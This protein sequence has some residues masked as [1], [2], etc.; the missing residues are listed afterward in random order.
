MGPLVVIIVAIVIIFL[1]QI[2]KLKRKDGNEI[3]EA[4]EKLVARELNKY[5]TENSRLLNDVVLLDD[6]GES[7]QIDHIFINENGVWIIE[8]KNWSGMIYGSDEQKEWTQVLA[9]GKEKNRVYSPVKQ[10]LTHVYKIQKILKKN[11]PLI[12]LV[13]FISADINNVRSSYVCDI[14][15]LSSII[16]KNYGVYLTAKEI[17]NCYQTIL[18]H[19]EKCCVTSKAHSIKSERKQ[20]DLKRGICPNCGG[21]LVER[22]GKSRSFYGCSNYPNC[23]FTM[24]KKN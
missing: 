22:M 17:E 12:S 2:E 18:Y 13:V 1:F 3:G 11:T 19:K 20:E 8:T 9:Y 10:N 23:R 21:R 5:K 15:R 16:K 24:N 14:N 4:G 7:Y 6:K